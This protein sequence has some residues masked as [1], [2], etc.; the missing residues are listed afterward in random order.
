MD[1]RNLSEEQRNIYDLVKAIRPVGFE[2]KHSIIIWDGDLSPKIV[3][4]ATLPNAP[5]VGM[6]I[7]AR[8]IDFKF[9]EVEVVGQN[10]SIESNDLFWDGKNY[11][12]GLSR[13]GVPER[14]YLEGL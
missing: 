13:M 9:S 10:F 11:H 14:F 2:Q 7:S 1:I 12:C 8:A 5:T 3:G 4:V 6:K